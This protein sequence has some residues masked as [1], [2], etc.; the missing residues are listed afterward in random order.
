MMMQRVGDRDDDYFD[1]EGQTCRHLQPDD[2]E[3]GREKLNKCANCVV[4]V[5]SNDA[6][7]ILGVASPSFSAINLANE[8]LILLTNMNACRKAC[9]STESGRTAQHGQLAA[10]HP[11]HQRMIPSLPIDTIRSLSVQLLSLHETLFTITKLS[12]QLGKSGR[13]HPVRSLFVKE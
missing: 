7:M 3:P 1:D 4:P 9:L 12:V 6:A 11:K 5:F 8:P 2:T 10:L 13:R